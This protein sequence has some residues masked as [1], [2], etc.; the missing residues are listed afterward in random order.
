M[1]CYATIQFMHRKEIEKV[2]KIRSKTAQILP[3]TN[4]RKGQYIF[5]NF[6]I[7]FSIE[8]PDCQPREHQHFAI[9]S[10]DCNDN[11]VFSNL[12]LLSHVRR[13]YLIFI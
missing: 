7:S 1:F 6:I 10:N 2:I 12:V 4:N 11:T 8:D 13:T 5:N 9:L 3:K